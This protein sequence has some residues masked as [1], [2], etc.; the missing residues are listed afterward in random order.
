M[1]VEHRIARST[2]ES[3][4]NR[5]DNC[6]LACRLCNRARGALS[7][8]EPGK[9]L[10]DPSRDAWASHFAVAGDFL[11]PLT[12]DGDGAHTHRA[13]DLDDE[14]KVV[15]RRL[16]RLLVTD[17]LSLLGEVGAEIG[18][19]LRLAEVIRKRNPEA[20]APALRRVMRLRTDALRA[21]E[22]LKLFAAIP[23]D[24]PTGCRC[25]S[26]DYELPAE[27]AAQTLSI[28]VLVEET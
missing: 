2:D 19:L 1:T 14:R 27:L 28:D 24:K 21:L 26:I 25:D 18:E 10:L 17:R 7:H 5:Y 11:R 6:V 20:F 23:S 13:Y 4:K 16:R 15:R 12:P 22:D 3:Q 8:E 9:R